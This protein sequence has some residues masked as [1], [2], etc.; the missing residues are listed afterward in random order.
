[1]TVT[2]YLQPIP[3]NLRL[4]C[5]DSIHFLK[6]SNENVPNKARSALAA[7]RLDD[8]IDCVTHKSAQ[9]A[10]VCDIKLIAASRAHNSAQ[11]GHYSI[12]ERGNDTERSEAE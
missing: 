7:L 6:I 4:A 3:T 2:S 9:K 11:S 12:Q 8:K 5:A 10:V 1:M